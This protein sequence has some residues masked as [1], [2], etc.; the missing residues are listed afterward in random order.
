MNLFLRVFPRKF[1]LPVFYCFFVDSAPQAAQV[2]RRILDSA[3][4][5][6][7]KLDDIGKPYFAD[8]IEMQL[9]V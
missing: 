5:G 7:G 8:D 1:L 2:D 6:N 4:N 3:A 9:L